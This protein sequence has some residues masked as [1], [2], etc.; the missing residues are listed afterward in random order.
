[1]IESPEINPCTY[2]QLLFD[3]GGKSIQQRKHSLFSKWCWG[4]WTATCKS[5]RLA[6]SLTPYTKINLKWLN[7]LNIRKKKKSKYK[8]GHHKNPKREHRKN[9]L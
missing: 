8:T 9:I 5:M 1:M 4:S 6:H 2:G 3:K 7:D